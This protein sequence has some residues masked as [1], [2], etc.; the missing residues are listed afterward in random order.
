VFVGAG[1]GGGAVGAPPGAW[2]VAGVEDGST[3]GSVGEASGSAVF[4]A[5]GVDAACVARTAGDAAGCVASSG[6]FEEPP[7]AASTA[8]R[9]S[10]AGMS[11]LRVFMGHLRS[12]YLF[13]VVSR[14]E[15]K[16]LR[17]LPH[18]AVVE[19]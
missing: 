13:F 3:A 9:T 15:P 1:G 12:L 17:L 14:E 18:A 5:V 8:P 4:T 19:A 6:A 10:A 16:T 2:P 7:H 11:K